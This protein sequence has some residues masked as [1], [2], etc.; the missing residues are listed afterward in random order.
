MKKGFVFIDD[1][2]SGIRWDAKYAT[3][4]NFTGRPV[5]GYEINRIAGTH[6]LAAALKMVADRAAAQGYGL[7]LFDGYRPQRAVDCFLRWAAQPEDGRMKERYYPTIERSEMV[8]LGYVASKSA[9]SRGSTIDLTLFCLDTGVPLSM[10][11]DFD[12]MDQRSHHA[13]TDIPDSDAENRRRL[14]ALMEGC[15][16]EPFAYEW[17][18]YSLKNEPFPDTYFDF[19]IR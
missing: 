16:F 3:C 2:V 11:S 15:G 14:L 1:I 19:P 9:H 17:W 8:S 13:S 18:H 6:A 4:D 10:G 12:F 7:M 5:D